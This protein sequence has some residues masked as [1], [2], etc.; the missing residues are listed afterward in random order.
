LLPELET[1]SFKVLCKNKK[2]WI[3]IGKEIMNLRLHHCSE[4]ER[5][6]C[7]TEEKRDIKENPKS[8]FL[9]KHHGI[10]HSHARLQ[11]RE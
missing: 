5:V 8:K 1:G 9:P 11:K 2:S 4:K 6:K 10:I 7:R 3:A